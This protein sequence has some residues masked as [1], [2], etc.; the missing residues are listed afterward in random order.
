MGAKNI[1]DHLIQKLENPVFDEAKSSNPKF[2]KQVQDIKSLKESLKDE[3]Q[4]YV[5][6]GVASARLL[7]AVYSVEDVTDTLLIRKEFPDIKIREN[8]FKKFRSPLMCFTPSSSS[9]Q[10]D[11]LTDKMTEFINQIRDL[12]TDHSV[13]K[14]EAATTIL[15]LDDV[16]GG[17]AKETMTMSFHNKQQQ[18][19]WQRISGLRFE[20]EMNIVVGNEERIKEL[21]SLI[22]PE[23]NL[24]KQIKELVSRLFPAYNHDE[25]DENDQPNNQAIITEFLLQDPDLDRHHSAHQVIAIV[26]EEGSGKT[27]LARTVY[28]R[29]DVKRRFAKRA[30]VRV[31]GEAKV[32]DVLID[33][34]Q[35]IDD[36]TVAD[37]SAPEGELA[38]SLSTLLE[39]TSYLIVVED[40]ETPQVWKGLRDALYCY[41]SSGKII[42]TTRNAKN[43]PPEA[44]AAGATLHLS[45]LNKEESWKLLLKKVPLPRVA[46]SDDGLN[47]SSESINTL[48]ERILKICGG[49]PLRVGLLG[50]LLSTKEAN[51]Q[52]WSKVIESVENVEDNSGS[53]VRNLV[54]LSYQ[55]LPSQLQQLFRCIRLFP[56]AF[57]I[58][59]RGLICLWC[60]VATIDTDL[61]EM[62]F[63]ELVIRNLIYV[64]KWRLDGTP[65]TCRM[66]GAVYDAVSREA[67]NARLLHHPSEEQ[68]PQQQQEQQ[69]R[70]WQRISDLY[71]KEEVNIVGLEDQMKEL[72]SI[73]IP[74][75]NH[76]PNDDHDRDRCQSTHQIIA[77][78]GERGSGKTTLAR[79]VYD[80]VDVKRH[81]AKRAWIRVRGDAKFRD[82]L[83]DILQ[84]I[85][86]ETLVEASAPEADLVSSLTTL[87]KEISYL[88]VVED[89]ETS[90]AWQVL[91]G[92]LNASSKDSKIILTTSNPNNIPPEAEAAG[93]TLH[94]SRLNKEESW[95]LLLKKVPVATAAESDDD[96]NNNSE[97]INTFKE[98][99][100]EICGGLPL[101]ISLLGGLLST[102]EAKYWSKVI[103]HAD[104]SRSGSGTGSGV[105]LLALSYKGLP[106]QLKPFFLYVGMFPRGFEIP[107]RRLI[108]LW[109][110]EGFAAPIDT[111]LAEM[112]FEELVIRNLIQ[113]TKWRLD[114]SPKMC[115]MP[116]AVY[117]VFSKEAENAGFFHHQLTEQQQSLFVRRLAVYLSGG[118][119]TKLIPSSFLDRSCHLRTYVAFD[120]RIYCSPA[121]EISTFLDKIISNRG[122]A[123]LTVLD[124]EGVYKP[125]LSDHVIGKL[126]H[127]S[128]LGLR[129][130]F[131]DS[132]P[133]SVGNL[134]YLETLDVK[135]TKLRYLPDSIWKAKKLQHLYLN[136]IHSAISWLNFSSPNNL[137]TLWGLS[138][139]DDSLFNQTFDFTKL[140]SLRK[141]GV[142]CYSQRVIDSIAE[143]VSR[144][145][146]LQ[147]LKLVY[148]WRDDY[149]DIPFKAQAN[150]QELYLR[151]ALRMFSAKTSSFP[152]NLKIVTLSMSRL[153]WDP[154]EALEKLCHLNILRIIGEAYEGKKM[155]CQAGGFPQLRVLKLWN[156]SS[157]E[158]W[159][160]QEAAMPRLRELEIRSCNKLKPPEGLRNLAATLKDIVLTNMPSTF[161]EEAQRILQ[162]ISTYTEKHETGKKMQCS[163]A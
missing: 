20:E 83:I 41:S 99:I 98:R 63:E 86:D 131:I 67:E 156:L 116:S 7:E 97:S 15:N 16:V 115:R 59:V 101:H 148:A 53:G 25:N 4:D 6:L 160:V 118:V 29:V 163:G 32:R 147:S 13:N 50:G 143:L 139:G 1:V 105:S 90:Q 110:A 37:A 30:W 46:E 64:T 150:L 140:A 106:S 84:Q 136:W 130:T 17:I 129:S 117:R 87:L 14:N 109:C 145:T 5:D 134:R 8:L 80:R 123:L 22:I 153:Y 33:I 62:Y 119:N 142:K 61:A 10:I 151:G 88:I 76:N 154:I 28:D 104:N 111:D 36:K 78:L 11:Y 159:T 18:Q 125:K 89:V 72:V 103:E 56:R 73:L 35:Q 82:V 71:F 114:G 66:P 152:R 92:A 34:L 77:I 79:T 3:D 65:K 12:S 135:H 52:Q 48:K 96:L 91:R 70:R 58:P 21:A 155:T 128:Y 149:S 138:M 74:E 27:I 93:P 141:L 9:I 23:K 38:S 49:L 146:R 137:Q 158:E 2:E 43:I 45:R 100:L 95:K 51:Y 40:V 113:V 47:N 75:Q 107:V 102:K 126:L 162:G 57:S 124:L 55:E 108:H 19:R 42:L 133:N 39:K 121:I 68:Q 161:G 24:E 81:F 157:L 120:N 44:E 144:S 54:D 112:Y 132:L 60:A 127:L 122:L 94:L 26:G 69:Q 31:R 85:D